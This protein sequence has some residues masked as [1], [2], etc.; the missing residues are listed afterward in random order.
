MNRIGEGDCDG[1]CKVETTY[2]E[3][4]NPMGSGMGKVRS[5]HE[6]VDPDDRVLQMFMQGEDGKRTP[7]MKI[8]YRR[9][10]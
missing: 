5:V 3:I 7:W 10:K 4:P 2:A 6:W 1:T 9:R 8:T